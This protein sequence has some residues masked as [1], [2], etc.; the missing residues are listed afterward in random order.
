MGEIMT[1][2]L[3]SRVG[4]AV[5]TGLAAAASLSAPAA[6][7]S[8]GILHGTYTTA[9]GAPLGSAL[10][11]V[12]LGDGSDVYTHEWTDADGRYEATLPAGE[13]LLGFQSEYGAGQWSPGQLTKACAR[14]YTVI[15]G[16]ILTV[17]EQE[18]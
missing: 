1:R 8:T 13:Y 16:E 17:D 5:A 10:V 18:L 3:L 11:S 4:L 12:W 14:L 6:A 9:G 15:D 7:S 2:T